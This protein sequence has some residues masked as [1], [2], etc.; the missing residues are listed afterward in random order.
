VWQHGNVA[1]TA[2]DGRACRRKAMKVK[3]QQ[4][5]ECA[6]EKNVAETTAEGRR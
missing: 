1:E 4:T 2:A 5:G 6:V 3:L